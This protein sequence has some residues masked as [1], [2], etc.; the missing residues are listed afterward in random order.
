MAT[1]CAL[2]TPHFEAL[3]LNPKVLRQWCSPE[4]ILVVTD[5]TD[6]DSIQLQAIY[7]ARRS[8]AKVLLVHL[9]TPSPGKSCAPRKCPALASA[10][11]RVERMARQLRWSGI[12]CEPIVV[13]GLQPN[14]IPAVVRSCRADRVIISAPRERSRLAQGSDYIAQELIDALD[15]PICVVGRQVPILPRYQRPT[16]RITLM[17]S[18]SAH[19]EIPIAFA[20]RFAQENRSQLALMH[21]YPKR[22]DRARAADHTV[23]NLISRLPKGA[24]REAEQ[25]CTVELVVREGDPAEQIL[26]YD[27]SVNQDSIIL[28]PPRVDSAIGFGPD[29]VDA[30]LRQAGCPVFIVCEPL[31]RE[32]S[33]R[34]LSLAAYAS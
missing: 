23:S 33:S 9:D 16:R 10:Q 14:E 26:K 29:S 32:S 12:G 24:L 11:E 13:R 25:I 18:L 34:T 22:T 4:I 31:V 27:A 2:R 7:Q 5:L 6:E 20:S 8:L 28:A 30:I 3:P 17:V 19:D 21:V 15:I 1:A